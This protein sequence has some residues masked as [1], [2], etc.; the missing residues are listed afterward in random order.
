MPHPGISAVQLALAI[1]VIAALT[2]Q[3]ERAAHGRPEILAMART[4]GAAF[5]HMVAYSHATTLDGQGAC[6]ALRQAAAHSGEVSPDQ[7]AVLRS[8]ARRFF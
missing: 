1:D 7:M 2:E 4:L 5:D 3:A 6:A 8:I